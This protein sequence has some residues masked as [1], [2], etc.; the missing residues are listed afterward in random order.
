MT[1]DNKHHQE[2]SRNN[3]KLLEKRREGEGDRCRVVR[4]EIECAQRGNYEA[5]HIS[6]SVAHVFDMLDRRRA[7]KISSASPSK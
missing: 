7:P 2:I 1:F 4:G 6:Q 5:T 3:C